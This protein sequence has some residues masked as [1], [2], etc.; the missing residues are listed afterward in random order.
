MPA[1]PAWP[2]ASTPR[3]FVDQPL[4]DG[5]HLSL[6]GPQAN[7]LGAVMRLKPGDPVRLFDDRTGEW[8]AEVADAGKRTIA[9][10]VT[11]QLREREAVPDIWLLFAPIKKGPIDWLVEKATELGVARM[12]PIITRR[13]IVDRV[14]LDRLR[15]HAIEAAEQCDRTA[16]PELAEPTT[17]DALLRGWDARRTLLFA[18][19]TGGTPLAQAAGAAPAA[20]LIGPEGGFTPEERD[21]IRATAGAVAIALGPR[22][23]RAETAAA[24][25]LAVWM[26]TAGDWR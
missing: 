7:Y 4:G 25:A 18:D 23:L 16:L 20:I 6:D 21:R 19:E 3:L 10:T 2:P 15:A 9:L 26:A 1:T 11:R 14:N 5:L 13:T 22:I 8:L 12:Q 17:L 24:A